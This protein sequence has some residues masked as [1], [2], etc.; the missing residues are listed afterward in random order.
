[1]NQTL[2]RYLI[3]STTTFLSA[4]LLALG[5][6]LHNGVLANGDV[7]ASV[8]FGVVLVAF[9]A[10]VKALVEAYAIPADPAL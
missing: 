8:I 6:Q 3:S 10:G 4:F 5:V 7:Q 1:M 9:R 2:K